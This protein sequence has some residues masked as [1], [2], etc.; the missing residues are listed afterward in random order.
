LMLGAVFGVAVLANEVISAVTGHPFDYTITATGTEDITTY[1][2][3]SFTWTV[4][5]TGTETWY[6]TISGDHIYALYSI[7]GGYNIEK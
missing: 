2:D 1:P 7:A 5:G 3:Q 6:E 4:T